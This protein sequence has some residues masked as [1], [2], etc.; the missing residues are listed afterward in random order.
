MTYPNA[1]K[2][3]HAIYQKVKDSFTRNMMV[4][5]RTKHGDTQK[6]ERIY[7]TFIREI[8]NEM[9]LTFSE[10][11]S[12]QPYDFRINIP[13]GE[14]VLKLEAKKTDSLTIYFNDTCPSPDA[15]Y[16]IFF[17]GKTYARK[18][19][20]PSKIIGVNGS[21]FI[22]Q[23]PWIEEYKADL[24]ALKQKYKMVEGPMTVYPRPTFKSDIS[25][26]L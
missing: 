7:I 13:G 18:D 4:D 8:L 12:Q 3:F 23:C 22:K 2:L 26:L 5:I 16:I 17:T 1:N 6:A 11:G 15:Y 19:D 25:F 10:A 21:E 20:I 9:N 14:D 24:D